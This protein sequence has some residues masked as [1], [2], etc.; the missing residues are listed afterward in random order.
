MADEKWLTQ[1]AYDA[2]TAE[3]AEREGPLRSA[4]GTRIATAREEGDLKE[5]GGYHAAREEQGLNEA[6]VVHL[7][8]LL[9]SAKIGTPTSAPDEAAHGKV[10]TVSFPALGIQET[11][12]LASREEAPHASIEVYSPSSPLGAAINGHKAGETVQYELPNGKLMNAEIVSVGEYE[13]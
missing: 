3:L 1:E 10:V 13:G 7:R 11:F 8:Q 9:E 4:I 12:L 2:L 5:N 6:R